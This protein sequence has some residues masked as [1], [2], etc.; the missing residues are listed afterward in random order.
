MHAR[1]FQKAFRSVFGSG[2]TITAANFES[3]VKTA[4]AKCEARLAA[5]P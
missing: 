1:D 2:T 5:L 4:L 3:A